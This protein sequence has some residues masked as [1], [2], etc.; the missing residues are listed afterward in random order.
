MPR[1]RGKQG[2]GPTA[3]IN[4]TSL[5]DVAFTLLVIF[6]ITAPI[7]QGGVEVQV[8]RA[9]A[10]TITSP[11]GVIVSIDREGQI[12][13][14]E[15][16]A[17]WEEFEAALSDAVRSE[18]ARNIYLRADEGVNYGRVLQ[19]LGAMKGLD[20]ASVGLVAEPESRRV[21]RA[22]APQRGGVEPPSAGAA[23]AETPLGMRRQ[24]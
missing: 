22:A 8:P 4:M 13:I 6:I 3:E 19:V 21:R 16:S 15:A 23:P 10:E 18:Q 17:S 5:I 2:L 1:R 11:D 20:I 14:G 9:R 7:M 24:E 12:Y